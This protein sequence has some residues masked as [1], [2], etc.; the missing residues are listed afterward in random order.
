V[1]R[2]FHV[3]QAELLLADRDEQVVDLGEAQLV[4][5]RLQVDRGLALALQRFF[6]QRAAVRQGFGQFLRVE[7][8]ADLGAGAAADRVAGAEPVARRAR[9]CRARPWR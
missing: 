4:R 3:A 6:D 1:Q 9:R 5:Q 2:R 7:P 8:G